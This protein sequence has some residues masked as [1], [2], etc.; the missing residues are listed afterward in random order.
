M[1]EY[2]ELPTAKSKNIG[3]IALEVVKEPMFVL[4]LVC[5]SI[6]LL[7]GDYTEGIMLSASILI[8]IFITFYQY[9]KTERAIESL[10]QLSSPK[11]MV[12][13]NGQ[14][15]KIPGR[16]IVIG[17][18][19]LINEGDRIPAD[20][21]LI[22]GTNLSVDESM[23]T[24]ESIP[25]SK[26]TLA[27]EG[28]SQVFS[29]T[30]VVQGSGK[31]EVN[32]IGIHTEFG[33]IGKSLQQIVQD[34]TR[35]Q[36]E[37]KVLIRNLFII[38]GF[39]SV[40]VVIA[41]Y[42][43]RGD[44]IASLLSGLASA[45][46]ILPEEFPVVL[47]IFLAIGAWRLS[48][49]NV[50]TRNPSAIETL[51]SAT[52]LCSDK[53][54]TI[55]Q[56]NMVLSTL[57]KEHFII[58]KNEF[59][60]NIENIEE[61]IFT[62]ILA[63]PPESIDPMERAVYAVNKRLPSS[64]PPSFTLRKEYPLS[65][66]LFVMTRILEDEN[67]QLYVGSKGAPEAILELCNISEEEKIHLLSK[68]KILAKRGQRILGVAKGKVENR[69]F[70]VSQKDFSFEFMGFLGFEDPIRPEVPE[71]IKQCYSAGIK[72]IM[73]TGDYPETAKNIGKQAG[74]NEHDEIL[75][76]HDL[77]NLTESEL[78][79]KIKHVN[80][81]ARIIPEQ[82]LQIIKALKANGEIVA[83]TGDGV[84][85][86]PALKAADIGI[87]MGGKGTD[88][89]RESSSLVLLDDNF[90]SIVMAIK[91]GRRIFDNL[92]KAMGY[93][94]AIHIPIIGL[95]L[96][97]AF[98]PALPILLM[99]L[100]I[101]FMELI[102]DPVCSIAFESEKEEIGVMKRSPR[103]PNLAFFGFKQIFKSSL[104]GLILLA[105]VL[106]V[107]FFSMQEGHTEGEIRAIAITSLIIGNIFLIL[108]TLSKTR[109]VI[110]VIFEDNISLK[111]ILFVACTMMFLLI[112][113]PYL[114]DLFS[115]EYPGF[116]HFYL[117]IVG[118][119]ALLFLMEMYKYVQLKLKRV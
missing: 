119:F 102:I 10:R 117:A 49:Q 59:E 60:E 91:S 4:L 45:M 36:K 1:R 39:L 43:T 73:I 46:A 9:Q 86:A 18:I 109:N 8:I 7:L 106:A 81:F 79:E 76:G 100:H 23:L 74:L 31:L 5:S 89:A 47:T 29:G 24:G 85:D 44:F 63:S 99:P 61:L 37:M 11:A 13:R 38:G 48:Q 93:I 111:I 110:D 75:T 62:A 56:N 54:G 52:V 30:L 116:K 12:I 83:M 26:D 35:L 53:T 69:E 105:M 103:D 58:E 15:V 66:D 25:V 94:I 6:Y 70:P 101:V 115:F 68:V 96:L 34:P 55:T 20:G 114:R 98:F 19:V 14:T 90:S 104:V 50:L 95:A 16:E 64:P 92:Q 87:S 41:F 71:A 78:K 77:K 97:P 2:N 42:L 22:H 33:K 27:C 112:S 84:N 107:Y 108:T 113:V 40:L 57:I 80:I 67:G 88:V 65:K 32:A 82:K 17:D 51:G 72:V 28:S 3:Q 118:G 21:L